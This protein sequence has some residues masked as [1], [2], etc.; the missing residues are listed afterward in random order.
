MRSCY[1]QDDGGVGGPGEPERPL[2]LA[3]AEVFGGRSL[4][5]VPPGS[6][7]PP[8]VRDVR[9]RAAGRAAASSTTPCRARLAWTPERTAVPPG[10]APGAG[11]ARLRRGRALGQLVSG[12]DHVAGRGLGLITEEWQYCW[13]PLVEARLVEMVHLGA[14][15]E[16]VAV[17]RLYEAEG[18]LAG[19]GTGAA[20]VAGPLEQE[21]G[22]ASVHALA[23]LVAQTL[24]IGTGRAPAPDRLHAAYHPRH[25]PRPRLRGVGCASAARAV[26]GKGRARR[27]GV[28]GRAARP[29]QPGA[30]HGRLPGQRPGQGARRGRGRRHR[31]PDRPARAPARRGSGG[32]RRRPDGR[33]RDRRCRRERCAGK[34]RRAKRCRGKRC[35][36]HRG[37]RRQSHRRRAR[38]CAPPGRGG[39][40]ARRGGRTARPGLHRRRGAR[41]CAGHPGARRPD[42]GRGPGHGRCGSS[43][44]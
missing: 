26:A 15:L 22:A 16:A 19:A 6:A 17:A 23:R 33:L 36:R 14:T 40:G 34:R 42:R 43:A 38:A 21:A 10:E 12:P 27:R 44:A 2:G 13:T 24:V 18:R 9:E 30:R 29:G 35:R 37:P 8:L 25:R 31:H 3:I 28:R 5:D 7:S 20:A 11:A 41:R 32:R 1:V 4:G 39:H